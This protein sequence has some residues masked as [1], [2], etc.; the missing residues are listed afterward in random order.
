M[1][2]SNIDLGN[3]EAEEACF[4]VKWYWVFF[5]VLWLAG[6]VTAIVVLR[7]HILDLQEYG[8]LGVF[9]I[10]LIASGTVVAMIPSVPVVFALGGILNPFY[11]ALIAA[12]G[13]TIGESTGYLA[14]R[15]GSAFVLR[16][17]THNDCKSTS[18]YGRLQ[19]WM[20]VKGSLAIFLSAAMFNPFFSVIGATAGALRVPPW[21]F[22]L[23]VFAGK[24][25]K[26]TF[27][28]VTGLALLKY[29]LDWLG[30]SL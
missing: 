3:N 10:S 1:V 2:R 18:I 22:Y 23:L 8:Y 27:V 17:N 28:A 5:G 25:I 20:R 6:I 21:K 9:I 12:L 15:T 19:G 26:W 24:T 14:G 13:E 30:I 29:V 16:N 7:H 11:V 4:K